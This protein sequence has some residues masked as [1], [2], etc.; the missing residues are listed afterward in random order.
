MDDPVLLTGATGFV[1]R[2]IL[3]ELV[4]R[5]TPVEAVSR[6]PR[7]DA[8]GVRWLC[9]DLLDPTGRAHALAGSRA[10]A[11]I[12]AAWYVEHGAFWHAPENADWRDA[13]VA[14]AEAFLTAGGRRIVGI[15]TCAEYA[16]EPDGQTPWPETRRLAPQTPYGIAKVELHARLHEL[17]QAAGASLIWARLFHLYGPGEHPDRFVPSLLSA[18]SERRRPEVRAAGLVRDFASTTHVARC[19]LALL[20]SGAEGAFNIGS[21]HPLTLGAL[22]NK[23]A[24]ASGTGIAP[25]LHH[26]PRDGDPATMVPDLTRLFDIPGMA[27]ETVDDGLSALV[28]DAVKATDNPAQGRCRPT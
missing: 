24:L 8:E 2:A 28:R 11:L 5:G 14:L 23:I 9:A 3:A 25:D 27:T 7:P 13:S 10:K 6:H 19:L 4:A 22:A 26:V 18:L 17:C 12:H 1:G 16:T 20:D 15:G 21:G